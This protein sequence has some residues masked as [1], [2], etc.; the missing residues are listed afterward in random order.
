MGLE[1]FEERARVDSDPVDGAP[2]ALLEDLGCDVREVG[3]YLLGDV[4]DDDSF[5]LDVVEDFSPVF[6]GKIA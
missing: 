6:P 3:V 5:D 4:V 2:R 1:E